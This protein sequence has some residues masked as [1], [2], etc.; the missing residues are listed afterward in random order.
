MAF[1]LFSFW[2]DTLLCLV[3]LIFLAFMAFKRRYNYWKDK[4]VCSQ[5]PVIPFGNVRDSFFNKKHLGENFQDIYTLSKSQNFVGAYMIHRP[6]LVINDLDLIK[7]VLVKDFVHF[8]DHGFHIDEEIDPLAAH[9]FNIT[10]E[11]WKNLRI[12]LTPTFTSSKM[13]KMF[14]I[15][16]SCSSEM[17]SFLENEVTGDSKIDLKE[18][19]AKLNTDII[20]NCA[21][22]LTCNS[23]KNPDAEFRKIGKKVVGPTFVED[24]VNTLDFFIPKLFTRLRNK[25]VGTEVQDFIY[26]IVDDTVRFRE[27]N[28]IIRNDFLQLLIELKHSGSIADDTGNQEF[29]VTI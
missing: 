20:G 24:V 26:K 18:V 16:A 11:K 17:M 10:G 19:L 25:V 12:K 4:G 23:F 5:Q 2:S 1:L 7:T 13:R 29:S 9:L 14:E 21:F 6:V 3:F 28:G 22:G 15:V 27:D 8:S